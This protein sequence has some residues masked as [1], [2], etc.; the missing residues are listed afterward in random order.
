MKKS[1][2]L[3]APSPEL[4]DLYSFIFDYKPA[5]HEEHKLFVREFEVLEFVEN[6][7]ELKK[8]NGL[9]N[10]RPNEVQPKRTN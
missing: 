10:C 5:L 3:H 8:C 2:L 1:V 7:A 6:L 4:G 9:R